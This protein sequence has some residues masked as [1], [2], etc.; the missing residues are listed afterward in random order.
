MQEITITT[1]LA[2]DE[3]IAVLLFAKGSTAS[4][5]TW[6]GDGDLRR[7]RRRLWSAF[8]VFT[9]MIHRGIRALSGYNYSAL[10]LTFGQP[11]E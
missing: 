10:G 3:D 9:I 8:Y 2:L 5:L 7:C 4:I 11:R 6:R 1:L